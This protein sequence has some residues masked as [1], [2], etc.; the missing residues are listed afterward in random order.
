MVITSYISSSQTYE[1]G[2]SIGGT[3]FVGD[4]GSESFISP[5]DYIARNKFSGGFLF[6]WNRSDRH[7][8]RFSAM[9][10]RTSGFDNMADDPARSTRG[11]SFSTDITEFSAGIEFTFWEFDLHEF[12]N[13][14]T[15]YVYTGPAYFFSKH[16]KLE[17]DEL[18]EGDTLANFAIPMVIGIKYRFAFHWLI[19]AEFGARYTF[20]DNLDGSTPSEIDSDLESED[21]GNL[22][23]EDWYLYSGITL[24]YTFGRK[25]CYCNF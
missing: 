20:T 25:P 10:F 18:I 15:P 5:N 3:N 11:L 22:N 23:S 16:Q 4:V 6:R 17:N 21:F 19:S 2:I 8:F 12:G 13:P 1:I 14:F 24:T 7:S 9:R